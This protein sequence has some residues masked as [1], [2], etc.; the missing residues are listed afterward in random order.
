MLI[1]I[2]IGGHALDPP[3]GREASTRTATLAIGLA[4]AARH[5]RVVITHGSGPQIGDMALRAA[6]AGQPIGLDRLCAELQGTLGYR[7]SQSLGAQ[8]A[9]LSTA[10]MITRARVDPADPRL[11]SPDKPIGPVLD[12]A[13]AGDL[14]RRFG[15]TMGQDRGGHR[16]LIASPLPLDIVE[17]EALRA[18][19]AAGVTVICAGGGGIP[20]ARNADGVPTG[21]DAVID[22]DHS[23]ALIARALDADALIFLTDVE[24][25]RSAWPPPAGQWLRQTS[26]AA[27]RALHFAAGS[28]RPKIEAAISFVEADR[29]FTA[30][31]LIEDLAA[32]IERRAGTIVEP[33]AREAR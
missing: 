31:G 26:P 21:L 10:T 29:G 8:D 13:T 14:A 11:A 5:H 7:L 24:A 3:G 6:L 32:L 25:V 20:V 18:L 2:A 17:L 16:R 22:K 27:L 28:M 19:V 15:W 30:I 12:A 4:A 9:G 33:D 1:V 23:A